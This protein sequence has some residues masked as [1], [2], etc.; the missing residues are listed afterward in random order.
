[1]QITDVWLRINEG[2]K[3]YFAG[4]VH[5]PK[6]GPMGI[7]YIFPDAGEYEISVRYQ[8]DG[9]K[10]TEYSFPLFVSEGG[11][12]NQTSTTPFSDYR[13]I[14]SLIVALALGFMARSILRNNKK[15]YE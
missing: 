2:R 9:E 6:F 5:K 7:T 13:V 10:I 11:G 8:N 15:K 1:V 4:G 3:T 14:V 12:D